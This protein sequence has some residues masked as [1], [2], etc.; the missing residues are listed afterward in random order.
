MSNQVRADQPERRGRS[1]LG[2]GRLA[3]GRILLPDGTGGL[4]GSD[5]RAGPVAGGGKKGGFG[6]DEGDVLVGPTRSM[7]SWHFCV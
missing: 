1:H 2:R 3:R 4:R 5:H 6:R 7:S